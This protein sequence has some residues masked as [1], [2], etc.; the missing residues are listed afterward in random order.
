METV[1]FAAATVLPSVPAFYHRPE[2][3]E[4][5][6]RQAAGTVLDQFGIEHD[7]LERWS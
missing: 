2:T 6:R 4:D 5:L 3:I 1:T 7:L